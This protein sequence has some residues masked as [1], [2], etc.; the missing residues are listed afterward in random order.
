MIQK[1]LISEM[2]TKFDLLSNEERKKKLQS[3]NPFSESLTANIIKQNFRLKDC[4]AFIRLYNEAKSNDI[5]LINVFNFDQEIDLETT[6][7]RSLLNG[8]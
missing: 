1:D 7:I 8:K 2:I 6:I 5:Q 4:I 3:E